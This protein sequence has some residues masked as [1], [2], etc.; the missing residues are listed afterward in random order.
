[1]LKKT[2]I[3]F[4]LVP[5]F[6]YAQLQTQV[7]WNDNESFLISVN[8]TVE[9]RNLDNKILR[10]FT[11]DS[12]VKIANIKSALTKDHFTFVDKNKFVN[13]VS[14]GSGMYYKSEGD[15]IYRIDNSFDHKMTNGA[16]VF[17]RN[18]T[19]FKFGGYGYW[20]NRNMF[21]YFDKETKEWEFYFTNP[22][23][24]PPSISSFGSSITK[25]NFYVYG[26]S[27]VDPFTGES[28]INNNNVWSFNFNSKSWSNL[29]VSNIPNFDSDF[30][31]SIKPDLK[32]ILLD[33]EVSTASFVSFTNNQIITTS[34]KKFSFNFT[35][36]NV[37]FINDT[38][39]N[40][41]HNQD[42]IFSD[43]KA[44][45][46]YTQ[47]QKKSPI[48]INT[49]VLF[50]GLT[51]TAF[52]SISLI[53]VLILYLKYK[54]N[55]KPRVSD[56][57]IRYKGIS[58]SFKAKEKAIIRVVLSK[59]EVLSQEIYDAVEDTS[60]SYPQNNK[61]K[62]DCIKKVN[63]KIEKILGINNFIESKKLETDGRILIYFTKYSHLFV[64]NK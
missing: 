34:P 40:I 18:D 31:V 10:T 2:K 37:F 26:G 57:G 21:T 17:A 7:L 60:L 63:K 6:L 30:L 5:Y 48:Y 32:L 42:L 55:Q 20:S 14:I 56:F 49:T 53:I 43:L 29:G 46:D 1:M 36:D 27:L 22:H 39:F 15:T 12:L 19:V 54:R 50:S 33:D 35:G 64:T 51:K 8:N 23:V 61:I 13:I 16:N 47:P 9:L 59:K 25:D 62:N 24:I 41:N 44:T 4:F 38:V 3:F 58:Y 11:F 52:F 28:S 45:F